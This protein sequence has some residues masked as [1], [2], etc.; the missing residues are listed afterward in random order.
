MSPE[1]APLDR[2]GTSARFLERVIEA[3][4]AGHN[5]RFSLSRKKLCHSN[6]ILKKLW[7]QSDRASRGRFRPQTARFCGFRTSDS[8]RSSPFSEK[9]GSIWVNSH[10]CSPPNLNQSLNRSNRTNIDES[11][12]KRAKKC[13]GLPFPSLGNVKIG[14]Y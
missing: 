9:A 7:S 1:K 2:K 11:A 8:D 6:A 10:Q 3:D 12:G 13:C 4:L 14:R 5:S